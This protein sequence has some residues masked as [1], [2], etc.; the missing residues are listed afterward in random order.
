MMAAAALP[1]AVATF[2]MTAPWA[3]VGAVAPTPVS[4][5]WTVIVLPGAMERSNVN[6]LTSFPENAS[7]RQ[8]TMR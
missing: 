8:Q 7:A 6:A 5:K 1:A 2:E 3:A 4:L